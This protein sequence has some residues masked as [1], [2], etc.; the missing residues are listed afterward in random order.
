[1]LD[2]L[3][4]QLIE[5]IKPTCALKHVDLPAVCQKAVTNNMRKKDLTSRTLRLAGELVGPHTPYF[6]TDYKSLSWAGKPLGLADFHNAR[7]HHDPIF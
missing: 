4:L 7:S 1:M 5:F 2:N 6:L 3:Y